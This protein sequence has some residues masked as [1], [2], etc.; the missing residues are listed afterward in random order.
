MQGCAITHYSAA[1]LIY[2]NLPN[3]LR[4]VLGVPELSRHEQLAASDNPLVDHRLDP[5]TYLN[6]DE[7]Q[8]QYHTREYLVLVAIGVSAVDVAV[9]SLN[10][11][12][13][14]CLNLVSGCC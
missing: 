3:V 4:C 6:I 1:H 9:P 5:C 2:I 13:D 14:G 10:G 12:F 11:G 7:R 8:R